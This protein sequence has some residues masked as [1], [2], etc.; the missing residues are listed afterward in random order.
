MRPRVLAAAVGVLIIG[1]AVLLGIVGAHVWRWGCPSQAELERLRT[2]EE[3]VLAFEKSGLELEPATWS[4]ELRGA[5]AYRGALLFRHDAPGATLHVLVCK[6]R[7]G[8]SRFQLRPGRA[9]ERFRFGFVPGNNVAGWI[10]G[11]DQSAA[12]LRTAIGKPLGEL[13]TSVDPDSRCYIR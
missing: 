9:R 3:V 7:C 8:I 4:R 2:P 11:E 5:G 12:R 10:G 6:V 1:A 13:D